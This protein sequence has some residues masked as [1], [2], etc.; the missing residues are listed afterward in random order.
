MEWTVEYG[1]QDQVIHIK[2]SGCTN[3]DG[4]RQMTSEG[5]TLAAEHQCHRFIVDYREIDPGLSILEI[6]G[7][8]RIMQELGWGKDDRLAV[9]LAATSKKPGNI[10]FFRDVSLIVGLQVRVFQDAAK[11]HDWLES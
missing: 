10:F 11:A 3:V 7:L 4:L 9:L 5:L 1:Q 6:D 2:V 8:P